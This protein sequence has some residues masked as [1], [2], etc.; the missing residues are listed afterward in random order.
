M[1]TLFLLYCGKCTYLNSIDLIRKNRKKWKIEIFQDMALAPTTDHETY[2]HS[3][4]KIFYKFFKFKQRNFL[5][6]EMIFGI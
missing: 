4:D 2:N 6:Q 1:T 5:S 3:T